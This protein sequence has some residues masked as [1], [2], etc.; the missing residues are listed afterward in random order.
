M[1]EKKNAIM[2]CIIIWTLSVLTKNTQ[3]CHLEEHY[4]DKHKH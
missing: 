1:H 4:W 2:M 3:N